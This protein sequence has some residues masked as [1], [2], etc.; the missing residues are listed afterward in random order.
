MAAIELNPN[1]QIPKIKIKVGYSQ[2]ANIQSWLKDPNNNKHDF[3]DEDEI[4]LKGI[5]G[6]KE[7]QD[8]EGK[9]FRWEVRVTKAA[10]GDPGKC[11]VTVHFTQE[12]DAMCEDV[13]CEK[14]FTG[15]VALC[16][17]SALFFIK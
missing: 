6:I 16:E 7:T 12:D 2:P 5:L 1:K 14:E 4:D 11:Y 3:G 17:G 9:T 15:D 13:V 10:T 8:V